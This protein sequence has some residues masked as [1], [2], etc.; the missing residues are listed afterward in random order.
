ME[1]NLNRARTTLASR[2]SSSMSSAVE[3]EPVS[4]YS[5][6]KE[7]RANGGF[8]PL[9]HRQASS[10]LKED[11]QGHSR[12][13]SETAVPSS[14]QST[15]QDGQLEADSAGR[16]R[17]S[18]PAR[19]W[20]W[21]GLNRSTSLAD[22]NKKALQPLNEDGPAPNTFAAQGIE[23]EEED[24]ED[25]TMG[26]DEPQPS[27]N[28][29]VASDSNK[30]QKAGLSRARSTNQMRDLRDQVSDL[31]GKISTLKQRAREDSMRRRSLQSLRTPSPLNN[32][33][34]DYSKVPLAEVP[35]RGT[36][37]SPLA[38]IEQEPQA[39][40]VTVQEID[41][42]PA[43]APEAGL[44]L[45]NGQKP[46]V[47]DHDSGI[48]VHDSPTQEHEPV[49]IP[50]VPREPGSPRP[51]EPI[52][53]SVFSQDSSQ[54]QSPKN[55]DEE[56]WTISKQRNSQ[57]FDKN[58]QMEPA[59]DEV[60]DSLYDAQDYHETIGERHEDREDAFDYEHFFLHSSMGHYG[61]QR[62]STH[63][64]N[65][66]QDTERPPT[67]VLGDSPDGKEESPGRH[68]RNNSYD[69]VSSRATFATATE[70][71][72]KEE[73][74]EWTPRQTMA[75]TWLVDPPVEQQVN[76]HHHIR[77]HSQKAD[78]FKRER[79]TKKH[80]REHSVTE[81]GVTA[82]ATDMPDL[83]TYL[84]LVA[85]KETGAAAEE[86]R[87]SDSDRELANRVIK[88]LAKVCGELTALD[89]EGGKYEARVC[90]RKL[91]TARRHLDGEVNGEAF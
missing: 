2:P 75:G 87:V 14:L 24:T 63:S 83:L 66:S 81:N 82:P 72:G 27:Q 90:R 5:L 74:E 43:T 30:V 26:M 39:G 34:Q 58:M 47:T 76:G 70:G 8:S 18:E 29:A 91:D 37:L 54:E 36:G 22:R 45:Q 71:D 33:D 65:Y 53:R 62:G 55:S 21:N 78:E 35:N 79:S 84:A 31:K 17:S 25:V 77:S 41:Q 73:D 9:K 51:Y 20:F 1:G 12:V 23:E 64:S 61:R 42:R 86:F 28:A 50:E 3:R 59:A 56:P 38:A 67:M 32:A 60:E 7:R 85:S 52:E 89:A 13:F 40:Q 10:S 6:Q 68:M 44:P 11:R 16:D 80:R 4:L 69:S 15:G 46:F 57:V 88:S 49:A 48:G 19:N